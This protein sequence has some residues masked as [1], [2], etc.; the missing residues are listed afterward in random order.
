MQTEHILQRT[1]EKSQTVKGRYVPQGEAAPQSTADSVCPNCGARTE[2]GQRFCEDCGCPLG[3]NQCPHCQHTIEP[4]LAL[5]PY[6]GEPIDVAHCSFCGEPMDADEMFCSS[7][8]NPR[9]GIACPTC[10]TINY[11]SFCRRCN[12]PLNEMAQEAIQK[13]RQHP[14]V[15]RARQIVAEMQRMQ[16]EME[17]MVQEAETAAATPSSPSSPEDDKPEMTE[18]DRKQLDRFY[19]LMNMSPTKTQSKPAPTKHTPPKQTRKSLFNKERMKALLDEYERQAAE[20][21]ATAASMLPDPADPPEVQRNFLCAC[22]IETYQT[23]V[24]KERKSVG[25]VC[26]FCG[27]HHQQ[28]SDCCRPELGGTWLYQDVETIKKIKSSV[29]VY[30]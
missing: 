17:R 20:L 24:I 8:G 21:Q 14:A 23:T 4:G 25:W 18:A 19:R 11:R 7:C 10:S 30:M 28:P 5:C 3:S 26:N 6:C 13:A 29:T 27:C 22:L 15:Q 16:E 1:K 2:Q 12:T 9:K